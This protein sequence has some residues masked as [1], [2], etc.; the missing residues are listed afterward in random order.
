V[1]G[2]KVD[3]PLKDA[4]HI[5]RS[6]VKDDKCLGTV[7]GGCGKGAFEVIGTSHLQGLQVDA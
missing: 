1:Q 4:P 3:D 2:R 5:Q 7:P 6:A